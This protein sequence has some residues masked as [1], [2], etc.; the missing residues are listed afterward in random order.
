MAVVVMNQEHKIG[1]KIKKEGLFVH[2][3]IHNYP[4]P[5]FWVPDPT[6][7]ST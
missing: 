5:G 6:L 1:F 4:K 2:F 7:G 3:M